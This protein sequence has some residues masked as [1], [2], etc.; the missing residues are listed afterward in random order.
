MQNKLLHVLLFILGT[1]PIGGFLAVMFLRWI[2][3]F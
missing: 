1:I 3:K 2:Y